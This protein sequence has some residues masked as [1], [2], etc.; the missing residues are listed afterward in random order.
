[1]LRRLTIKSS[2]LA[3]ACLVSLSAHAMADERKAINVPAGD[4]IV[5]LKTFALQSG[6]ELVYRSDELEGMRTKGVSGTLA[7]GE[8]VHKLI[9]GTSLTVKIDPSGAM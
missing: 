6:V 5:A 7:P 3:L 9:E 1:M 8:A 4:L 2:L